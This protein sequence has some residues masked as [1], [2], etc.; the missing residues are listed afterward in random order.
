MSNIDAKPKTL[1]DFLG[2]VKAHGRFYSAQQIDEFIVSNREDWIINQ[3]PKNTCKP[4]S[5]KSSGRT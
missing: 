3:P 1:V 5:G 4:D 2:K